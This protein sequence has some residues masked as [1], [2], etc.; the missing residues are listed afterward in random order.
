MR[1]IRLSGDV[2]VMMAIFDF[3]SWA[4][5]SGLAMMHSF[6]LSDGKHEK[7]EE[8]QKNTKKARAKNKKELLCNDF[9]L[10]DSPVT[11]VTYECLR[12]SPGP[13]FAVMTKDSGVISTNESL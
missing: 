7:H 2:L 4:A 11:I 9:R 8:K 13:D 10:L 3:P 12:L 6:L 5:G 1:S